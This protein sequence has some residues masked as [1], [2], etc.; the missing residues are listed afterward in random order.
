M[1]TNVGEM[2]LDIFA[3]YT[4][5]TTGEE[6]L[7]EYFSI[8]LFIYNVNCCFSSSSISFLNS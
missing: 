3:D 2:P 5:D 8:S 4:T 1:N 6:F 7:Q